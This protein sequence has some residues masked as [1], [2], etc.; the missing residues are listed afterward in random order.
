ITV[1]LPPAVSPRRMI[2]IPMLIDS[3]VQGRG[4]GKDQAKVLRAGRPRT[5]GQ[6]VG[7]QGHLGRTETAIDPVQGHITFAAGVV[8][9]ISIL[10]QRDVARTIAI[11]AT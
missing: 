7:A 9:G 11:A 5:W 3:V 2:D 4:A 8:D 6:R 1:A 10:R